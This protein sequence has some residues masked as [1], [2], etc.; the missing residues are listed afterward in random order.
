LRYLIF[1]AQTMRRKLKF[2]RINWSVVD[3]V[4]SNDNTDDGE[5]DLNGKG[6]VKVILTLTIIS[7]IVKAFDIVNLVLDAIFVKKLFDMDNLS[8][9][10]KGVYNDINDDGANTENDIQE[11]SEIETYKFMMLVATVVSC[12][13]S[14]VFGPIVLKL[15]ERYDPNRFDLTQVDMV[16]ALRNSYYAHWAYIETSTFLFEDATAI[17]IY[18]MHEELLEDAD[19][20]DVAN[21]AT[22]LFNGVITS[23]ILCYTLTSFYRETEECMQVAIMGVVYVGL[24]LFPIYLAIC[25]LLGVRSSKLMGST[26]DSD[27]EYSY[28]PIFLPLALSYGFGFLMQ[29]RIFCSIPAFACFPSCCVKWPTSEGFIL[30]GGLPLA[31]EQD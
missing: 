2:L 14:M 28:G 24:S 31:S 7:Y 1:Q 15:I 18:Y 20:V 12:A 19:F 8:E 16:I 30:E 5:D 4:D 29:L 3:F 11:D 27:V 23:C 9:E 21:V 6:L 13:T 17:Y 25:C 26:D 10:I 22:S